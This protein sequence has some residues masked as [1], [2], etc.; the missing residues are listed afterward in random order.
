MST[1]FREP[2]DALVRPLAGI[3]VIL[4]A[5]KALVASA[6][7]VWTWHLFERSLGHTAPIPITDGSVMAY[8]EWVQKYN[9]PLLTAVIACWLLWQTTV[10]LRLA[11]VVPHFSFRWSPSAGILWWFAPFANLVVPYRV[12]RELWEAAP[13][14]AQALG[15]RP[16]LWWWIPWDA[17]FAL[18]YSGAFVGRTSAGYALGALS[19][20][21]LLICVWP[22][23]GFVRA[24]TVSVVGVS[25]PSTTPVL[26]TVVVEP[27]IVDD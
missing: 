2:P 1:R 20:V 12:T 11:S 24:L 7:M 27:D 23:I 9:N 15:F 25:E 14:G 5:L 3:L 13:S 19:E 26:R 10:R 18:A 22:A 4:L 21:A 6:L 16:F 8:V 17:Q